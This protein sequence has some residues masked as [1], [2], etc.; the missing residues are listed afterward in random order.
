MKMSTNWIIPLMLTFVITAIIAPRLLPI[1]KRLKF[2]QHVR[3]D[4]P[5]THLKKQG[6]PTM[7]GVI[8]IIGI[9]IA[10]FIWGRQNGEMLIVLL[11]M[12]SFGIIGFLDDW[13]KIK[14]RQSEGLS[15]RQKFGLQVIVAL[16]YLFIGLKTKLLTTVII[17]PFVYGYELNLGLFFMPIMLVVILGTVNGVNLTDGLDGLA[18]SVTSVIS[19]FFVLAAIILE[20]NQELMPAIVTGALIAFL[21]YNTYPAKVFMGD[22]GSLALGGFVAAMAISLRIPLFILL[23]GVIYLIESLSVIIQVGYYKKHKKRIFKMAPIHHHFELSGMAETQVVTYFTIITVI[24]S[25]V[26]LLAI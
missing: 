10:A 6:T 20:T 11:T 21:L 12:L 2:G 25:L 7:G 16:A 26:A 15:A 24:M 18:T 1:L 8:F 4:G 3:D 22:T 9:V 19:F 13:L 14:K 5:Q 23:F 17:I